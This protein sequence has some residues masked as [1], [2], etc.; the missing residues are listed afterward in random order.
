MKKLTIIFLFIFSVSLLL[1]NNFDDFNQFEQFEKQDKQEFNRL[2]YKVKSCINDWDFS[3]ARDNL[4]KM[5]KYIT[6]KSDNKIIDNL[7]DVLY[8]EEKRKERYEEARRR[9][10]ATKNITLTDCEDGTC[11]IEVNGQYDGNIY[12]KYSSSYGGSYN[13]FVLGS[14][15][16]QN[17][18]GTYFL[19][20]KK[21]SIK[22]GSK[23]G[24]SLSEALYYYLKC[25]TNGSY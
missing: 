24:I 17:I 1:A 5:K 3:C 4:K 14:T 18:S 20:N 12:Y 2:K 15:N 22:C 9:A 8:A 10:S 16:V 7:W 6:T 25:A 21:L 11:V 23:Y 19:S 13:I